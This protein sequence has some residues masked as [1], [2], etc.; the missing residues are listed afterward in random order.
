MDD[1]L[2]VGGIATYLLHNY[3][4]KTGYT[5]E[6]WYLSRKLERKWFYLDNGNA[7]CYIKGRQPQGAYLSLYEGRRAVAFLSAVN[8]DIAPLMPNEILILMKPERNPMK[9]KFLLKLLFKAKR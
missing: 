7:L 8:G 3:F 2:H 6:G 5:F 1:I 4:T 9:K